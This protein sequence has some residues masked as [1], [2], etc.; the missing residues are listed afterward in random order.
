MVKCRNS[1]FCKLHC[2]EDDNNCFHVTD[3][4]KQRKNY[5]K[6]MRWIDKEK[7]IYED[8]NNPDS[9][10]QL[11]GLIRIGRIKELEEVKQ[12]IKSL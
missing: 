6:L 9:P 3:N 8:M 10:D 7:R 2:D 1:A 11:N 4:C 5:N 12:K